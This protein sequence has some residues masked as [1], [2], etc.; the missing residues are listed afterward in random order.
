MRLAWSKGCTSSVGSLWT[1]HR[2]WCRTC[3]TCTSQ[4]W[5]DGSQDTPIQRNIDECNNSIY[6]KDNAI[7]DKLVHNN[8]RSISSFILSL[9]VTLTSRQCYCNA[10][11]LYGLSNS[12]FI[13][14]IYFK[15]EKI[16]IDN[17][18][19]KL[20]AWQGRI[21][22]ITMVASSS[23]CGLLS[24]FINNSLVSWLVL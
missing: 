10:L 9:F 13:I 20:A 21:R 11:Q 4:W 1:P 7:G 2:D 12:L 23:R 16:S 22:Q 17:S 15:W 3:T 8:Y 5:R 24:V 14:R 19:N 6:S 18:G